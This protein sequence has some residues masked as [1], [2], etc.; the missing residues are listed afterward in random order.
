MLSG[1]IGIRKLNV[2]IETI[3][4]LHSRAHASIE[5]KLRA[6]NATAF[7]LQIRNHGHV[8]GKYFGFVFFDA[9]KSSLKNPEMACEPIFCASW[10]RRKQ[11]GYAHIIVEAQTETP[12]APLLSFETSPTLSGLDICPCSFKDI[13]V[14]I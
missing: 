4:A 5:L 12:T 1:F 2:S 14:S 8:H 3:I 11:R 7:E 10:K 13:I 6:V 9:R